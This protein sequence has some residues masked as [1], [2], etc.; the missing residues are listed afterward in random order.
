MTKQSTELVNI[1]PIE[2]GLDKKK[3]K[4]IEGAF[5]PKLAEQELAAKIYNEIINKDITPEVCEE[6]RELRLKLVKV[7]TGIS[8]IHRTEKAYYLAAGRFCDALKNK[9][10]LP[11]TQMEQGLMDIEKHFELI[12]IERLKQLQITRAQMLT[13]AGIEFIPE[14]LNVMPDEVWENYLN[15]AIAGAKALKEEEER[16]AKEEEAQ[17]IEA[18]KQAE[19]ER[20]EAEEKRKKLEAENKKLRE[21]AEKLR[22][23]NE[24]KAAKQKIIDEELAEIQRKIDAEKQ[25][26]ADELA[27]QLRKANEEKAR[28]EK[29]EEERK[30]AELKRLQEEEEAEQKRLKAG[31]QEKIQALITDLEVLKTKYTFQSEENKAKY[32]GTSTLLDKIIKY[33]NQ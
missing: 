10:T 2:Y 20:K 25:K 7:R 12:E 24:K 8:E 6:A 27:E 5:L 13:D 9:M 17:R 16:K 11:V 3:A 22:I 1:D 29:A 15:G 32:K 33:I 23:E 18:E 19:K 21:A 26:K 28:L 14:N 30:A 4:T 31:D